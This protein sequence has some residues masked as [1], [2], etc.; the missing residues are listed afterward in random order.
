MQLD[1]LTLP[2]GGWVEFKDSEQLS[3][4]QYLAV[5]A[6]MT[7]DILQTVSRAQTT[8]AQMLIDRWEIPG[9]PRLPVPSAK[10]GNESINSVPW[11]IWQKIE[12]HV[13]PV[14]NEML[15]EGSD[16]GDDEEA[17]DEGKA[18]PTSA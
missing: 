2:D 13:T 6:L 16:S 4:R 3:T 7:T 14:V 12:G 10:K 15:L 1:R 8:L 18:D 17:D 11:P 5:K 9:Q